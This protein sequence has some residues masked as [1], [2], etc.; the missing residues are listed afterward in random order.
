MHWSSLLVFYRAVL[1]ITYFP[2]SYRIG[3][4]LP[5][6]VAASAIQQ[7]DTH[8]PIDLASHYRENLELMQGSG[9]GRFRKLD[10]IL[11]ST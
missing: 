11:M 1:K 9:L 2:L 7:P 10:L 6:Y 8:C 5:I 4:P 3:I